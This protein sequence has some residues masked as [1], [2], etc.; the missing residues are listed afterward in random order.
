MFIYKYLNSH[1]CWEERRKARKTRT[2]SKS[3]RGK[4]EAEK[5][6]WTRKMTRMMRVKSRCGGGMRRRTTPVRKRTI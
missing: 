4:V 3:K 2:R 5:E 6:V 1:A